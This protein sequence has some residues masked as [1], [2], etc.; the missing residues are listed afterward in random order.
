[1]V[2][3][4]AQFLQKESNK[5]W[6]VIPSSKILAQ[7]SYIQTPWIPPMID[8]E[9]LHG[10]KVYIAC[11]STDFYCIV[12][13]ISDSQFLARSATGRVYTYLT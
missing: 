9:M 8:H 5:P 11:T 3:K 4:F 12:N 7:C 13:R 10:T 2:A 1:M 6:F